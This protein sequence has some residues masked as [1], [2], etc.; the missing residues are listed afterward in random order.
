MKDNTILGIIQQALAILE[1]E[2]GLVFGYG[3]LHPPL[4]GKPHS[5]IGYRLKPFLGFDPGGAR[6]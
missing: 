6:R 5:F 3:I 4:T 2:V 1:K